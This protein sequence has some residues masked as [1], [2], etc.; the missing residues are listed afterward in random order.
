M[1]STGS[2]IGKCGAARPAPPGLRR[3]A[4][5]QRRVPAFLPGA[6]L[7]LAAHFLPRAGRAVRACALCA[8]ACATAQAQARTQPASCGPAQIGQPCATAD[9]PATQAGGEPAL[10]LGA[11]NP[12][13]IVTGNKTRRDTDLP[14]APG[15]PGLEVVRHYNSLDPRAGPLGRGWAWTYDTRLHVAAGRAQIVQAD[16]SRV[17]FDLGAGDADN[18]VPHQAGT[19]SLARTASGWDWRWPDGRRLAFDGEGRLTRIVRPGGGVLDIARDPRPGP[20]HGMIQA[21]RDRGGAALTLH[22]EI[23]PPGPRLARVDTPLGAFVYEHLPAPD[24]KGWLLAS[25]TRPDGMQRRYRYDPARQNGHAHA[26]TGAE[27]ADA[28]GRVLPLGAWSYDREGRVETASLDGTPGGREPRPS[29]ADAEAPPASGRVPMSMR[30]SYLRHPDADRTGVTAIDTPAGTTFLHTRRDGAR[31]R[32]T[33]VSGPGCPGCPAPG[34][35]ARHDEAGRLTAINGLRIHADGQ[36]GIARLEVPGAGWPAL[37]LDYRGG[38]LSAWSSAAG[39]EKRRRDPVQ[40]TLERRHANGDLWVY[41]QDGQG[42]PVAVTALPARPG[43]GPIRLQLDWRGSRLIR[44]Q[45]PRETERRRYDAHGRL[46]ARRVSRPAL[47]G[48]L[49]ALDYEDRYRYDAEGRLRVHGLPEGGALRYRWDGPRLA[50]VDWTDASGHRHAVLR[51]PGSGGPGYVHANGLHTLGWLQEGR[52]AGLWV[53]EPRTGGGDSGIA[54]SDAS[55]ALPASP[56]FAQFLRYDAQ[57]RLSA[58]HLMVGGQTQTAAYA[59]DDASRLIAAHAPDRPQRHYAW[60]ADG[61]ARHAPALARDASGLPGR[62]AGRQLLHDA[63]HRLQE[64]RQDGRVLLRQHHDA[65]G[66]RI[67]RQDAGG[68]VGYLYAGHRLAAEIRTVDGVTGVT[69]RYIH[70]GWTPVAFIDYATPQPLNGAARATRRDA[71]LYAIHAD[72]AGLPH[73]VTDPAGQVRWRA[74]YDA[75]GR[76]E[77]IDGDLTLDLRLPG[78][79]HDAATGW[80]DNGLRTYDPAAG[81]YLQADPLGPLPGTQA[82]GYAAQ[83]PRRHADPLGLLLFAFDGT[84]NAPWSLTNVWLLGLAYQGPVRY[85]AGPGDPDDVNLDAATAHSAPLILATQ[86]ERLLAALSAARFDTEPV[87]ID[88]LGY[89]RGAALARHF[90]NLIAE[91]VRN[92]RF[93]LRDD[94]LGTVTACVGL[95]FMGLFDTVA[96]FGL[97]GIG[98][99]DYDLTVSD[100]WQWVAHAVALH[101]HRRLFPLITLDG[102]PNGRYV[103]SHFVGAHADIGGG[104]MAEADTPPGD[105]GDLSDVALNWM[106]WQAL[107]AGVPLGPLRDAQR[108]ISAPLLHDER[109]PYSRRLLTADR[110][111][112]DAGDEKTQVFQNEHPRYGEQARRDA[113]AFI[114]RLPGWNDRSATGSAAGRVD[115]DAYRQWLAREIGF[116][117]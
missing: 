5:W 14:S 18:C 103:E 108:V 113:E 90:G 19:G 59:Y 15:S 39:G 50:G 74:R 72:A 64:V 33:D 58:E 77:R 114:A 51:Q 85:H 8:L 46:A 92:G 61:S 63:L 107:A 56:L 53:A 102:S 82:Y 30:F 25:A 47:P 35:Q 79:V 16:G 70:A 4:V 68:A 43:A 1:A 76:A 88:L 104:Y 99:H 11:G 101:E 3:R 36:G 12:V 109:A 26:L 100:A 13:H 66:R 48:V 22:Y 60:H 87:Q 73:L 20:L 44:V 28:H 75:L 29:T 111:V 93:W 94:T 105:V 6:L 54:A 89:S 91:R 84:R 116:D 49:P 115:M 37:T 9:G 62:A 106:R 71:V 96:Q 112:Y 21:V 24:G 110:A 41:R 38:E 45:G 31:Y 78:Q 69:R 2:F 34:T 65:Q 17:D 27:L 67:L 10:N 98:N 86:W 97:L 57:G 42:R 95:R 52:L 117:F 81:H 80:H 32:L 40:G 55:P 7:G 83:Q 23:G